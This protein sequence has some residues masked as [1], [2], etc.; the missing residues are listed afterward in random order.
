M[1]RGVVALLVTLGVLMAPAGALAKSKPVVRGDA[2]TGS[3]VSI[4]KRSNVKALTTTRRSGHVRVFASFRTYGRKAPEQVITRLV[5][6]KLKKGQRRKLTLR[7]N[8]IGRGIVKGC[9][10]GRIIVHAV[11]IGG[12]AGAPIGKPVRTYKKLRRDSAK[13]R[14]GGSS[15]GGGSGGGGTGGG[16]GGGG[17]GGGSGGGG[18]TAN[19]EP[20]TYNP[21]NADRCDWLDEA[22]CL[23]PFPNNHFTTSDSTTDTK[24]RVNLNVL[25]M[26]R[27]TAQKPID[28]AAH[29]RS[30]GFSPAQ[31]IVTKVPGIDTPEAFNRSKI[32]PVDDMA[33]AFRPTQPLV[34]IDTVT[35]ARQMVWGELDVNPEVPAERTLAIRPGKNLVEGRRY[36]VALRDLKNAAGQTIGANQ[37]FQ[38]YRD[39]IPTTNAQVEARRKTFESIFQ[40]LAEAGIERDNLYRAW[41]FTV[42]SERNLTE[43]MLHIR[44][45]AFAEL[46]DNNLMDMKVDGSPPAYEITKVTD[47]PDDQTARRVEGTYT[48]P[49][50]LNLP[51][52][53][54]GSSFAFDPSK[55]NGPPL[56]L[57]G[58][59]MQASFICNIPKSARNS[60]PARPSLY[61]HGLFGSRGE[62][63]AGNVR[64]MGNESKMVFC[65]TDWIGMACTNTPTSPDDMQ[66]ILE[67]IAAGNPPAPPDCDVPNALTLE[68]DL[69]RF[70]ELPDRV[71][72]GMLNFLYLGRLMVHGGG[73]NADP[74]FKIGAD[75]AGV[76]D[77]RRL[78]Y[79]GNSQ[80]GIIGGSLM[81][82]MVD[83][84]R[85]VLG[86]PGMAYSTLLQR[87]VDFGTGKPPAP[88]PTDPESFLPEYA[89]AL[90]TSYPNQLQRQLILSLIQQLWDRGEANGYAN[91]MTSDPLRNTPPH[92][93][94]LHVA[95]GD[96]QVAQLAAESEARTIGAS[97]E[98]PWADPGRDLDRGDPV[99]GVPK[100]TSYPFKGSA[101]V[102]WDTGPLRTLPG[103]G[104]AG[105]PPPPNEN[106]PPEAGRDPHGAP[107]GT[108]N[109]RQQKSE[110]LKIDGRLIDACGARP[111]YADGWTGP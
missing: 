34:L 95:L 100:I 51:G 82:V 104:T 49:C 67:G 94:L 14:K 70:S 21:A 109:G 31:P 80:G 64:T 19:R 108:V 10:G 65:A 85:G 60:S 92:N 35:R 62:V 71:Q 37:A 7:L 27:N 57:P 54:A 77:T 26:P 81:A 90:Y 103:G 33:D 3:Q 66:S 105:T 88:D 22:D 55:T 1:G 41:D 63:N 29:N 12:R 28:P 46:G 15:G 101:I 84:D 11:R 43:R 23:L 17:T 87:S 39:G 97:A 50:Y 5:E 32:V 99:F 4:L 111:C 107:R 89:Y 52:C 18:A 96:H 38:I 36:V 93:V 73:F 79:D 72:Q 9:V 44:D 42:A 30:D 74:A 48:V 78:F 110:F 24:R 16:S 6:V 40:T 20:I 53:P 76:L 8:K 13:C 75:G 2:Q 25:S 45:A 91:H 68:T 56:R 58:N 69:S 98:T 106:I 59:T 86:V 47:D 102:L 61:G 83:G